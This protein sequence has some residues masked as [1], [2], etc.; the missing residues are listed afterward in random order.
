M[1]I[2]IDNGHGVETPGKR[3]PDGRLRE[4]R[5]CREIAA[6]LRARLL[7]A[8]V[9]AELI[10]PEEKDIP[11]NSGRDN[12]VARANK[13]CGALGAGNCLLVS[14]HCNAAPPNNGQWHAA[15][16]W[17]VYV[18]QNASSNSKRFAGLL[19]DAAAA[20]GLQVRKPAPAQKYWVQSLAI[21]RETL[22]PAV[23][24]ENLFQDNRQDVDYLLS[25]AGRTVI[26]QLHYDAITKYI[27]TK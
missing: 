23:L 26:I 13:I 12:R 14:I 8:G 1:K 5:Y 19:A 18:S 9:D 27:S 2:L 22:C 3:S 16:G 15:R 11:L 10:V 7:A 4:Y 21:C 25:E 20:Q 17:G 24:T 6:A